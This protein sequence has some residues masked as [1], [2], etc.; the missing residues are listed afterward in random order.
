MIE[1]G[2]NTGQFY[3]KIELSD[4]VN[5]KQISQDDIILVKYLD[6][7]YNAGE[8]KVLAKSVKPSKTF[9]KVEMAGVGSRVGHEFA[10]RIHKPDG[11]PIHIG[12]KYEIRHIDRSTP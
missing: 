4:T 9:A 3:A 1:T 6:Q 11:K 2:P 8:Q 7:S 5:G 12:D 10:L